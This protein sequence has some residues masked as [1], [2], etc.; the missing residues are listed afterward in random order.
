MTTSVLGQQTPA[1]QRSTLEAFAG[2]LRREAHNLL[3][4]PDLLWQQF[5]NRLQW[6]DEPVPRLL[7]PELAQRSIP[8]A[9]PWLKTKTPFRESKALIRTLAGHTEWVFTCAV[10][11]DGSFVVSGSEDETLKIWDAKT[12]KERAT[13]AG[14]TWWVNQCAVSP[15]GAFVVSGSRDETLKIWDA[16]TGKEHATLTGHTSEVDTCAVSPDGA[17]VVSGSRDKT[18]KIWD[19]NTGKER[20]TLTGHN[21]GVVTCAVSPD[22]AFVVS[23]SWDNTLKIWDT[24]TGRERATLTGHTGY[25]TGCAVSPDGAFVVSR[26][27]DKTLKIWDANTGKER[28]TLTGHN[29][30]VVTCA[31]SPDGAFVVSGS[32]DNTLKIWDAK[33]GKERATLA[34][35]TKEVNACAVSPDGSF[36]VSGSDDNTLKIWDAKTGQERSTLTGHTGLIG[37]CAVSPDGAFVVSGSEDNTLKIWDTKTGWERVTLPLLG[38]P[39]EDLALHPLQPLSAFGDIGGNMYLVNL[40]GIKY[41]SIIVTAVDLGFGAR[42]RCPACLTYLPLEQEWLGQEIACPEPGCDGRMRVN[43]FVVGGPQSSA[44]KSVVASKPAVSDPSVLISRTTIEKQELFEPEPGCDEKMRV[45]PFV[46]DSPPSSAEKS[47]A[48]SKPAVSDPSVLISRTTLERWELLENVSLYDLFL[49]SEARP[50]FFLL[51]LA[52]LTKGL[53]YLG[54]F[55]FLIALLFTINLLFRGD[56]TEFTFMGTMLIFIPSLFCFVLVGLIIWLVFS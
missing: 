27:E 56:P 33:T 9:T 17:F 6:E 47:V 20:A 49:P 26:S 50:T 16:K 23:G 40:I 5:H 53:G 25:V 1:E 31:V 15:D 8:G 38:N 34:G 51:F 36:V 43:P 22:G 41:K 48:A 30:G 32:W 11:P 2:V 18:L 7:A 29:R 54:S 4:R 44:S 28:A 24:K 42:V 39:S 14:H 52:L 13:L 35:H 12:G 3:H 19:A 55:L 21:S 37:T 45:T 10:S 46:E